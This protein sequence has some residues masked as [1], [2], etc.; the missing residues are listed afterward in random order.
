MSVLHTHIGEWL[1]VPPPHS[2]RDV[3]DLVEHRLPTS[4]V[5]RLMALGVTKTEIGEVVIPWRTLQHRRARREGLTI[6]ESDRLLRV[7]RALSMTESVYATRAHSLDWLRRPNRHLGD[8]SPLSL[9]STDTGIRMVEQLLGQI[10]E[11]M[12]I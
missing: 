8:R 7:I 6:D 11:G 5:D 10:D 9:V 1:G 2:G 12:F 3:L 4:A